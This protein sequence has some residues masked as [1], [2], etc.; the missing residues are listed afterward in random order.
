[1]NVMHQTLAS[2]GR[3][4]SMTLPQ[5]GKRD[6]GGGGIQTTLMEAKHLRILQSSIVQVSQA[7]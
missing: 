2:R 6:D 3:P 4:G 5:D 7:E 1:M